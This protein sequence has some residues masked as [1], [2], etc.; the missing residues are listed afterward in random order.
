MSMTRRWRINLMLLLAAL[1][2]G[3]AV[4]LA[5]PPGFAPLTSLDPAAVIRIEISDLS[6]RQILLQKQSTLW[7]SGEATANAPRIGQLLGL[8]TTPS[9][10][11]FP[12]PSDLRPF[13]LDPAPI[14]LR[15]NSLTL[16]F[17]NT[18]PINGWRYVRIGDQIHL[19]ADGFYHH[20]SAPPEAWLETP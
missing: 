17:G 14:R 15:L 10:E 2:L 13:G 9:L 4:W 7:R 6:G 18:D 3:V 1:L 5:Q 19:I 11:R 8:C 20:L 12:V 16:D